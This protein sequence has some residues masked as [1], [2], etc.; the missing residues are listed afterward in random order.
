MTLQSEYIIEYRLF[1]KEKYVTMSEREISKIRTGIYWETS[2]IRGW[3]NSRFT[4]MAF[5]E[6][7]RALLSTTK[8]STPVS[9]FSD[10]VTYDKVYLPSIEEIRFGFDIDL[11]L[12]RGAGRNRREVENAPCSQYVAAQAHSVLSH[13]SYGLRSRGHIDGSDSY[14][15]AENFEGHALVDGRLT[16][17]KLNEPMGI[18]PVIC[19]NESDIVEMQ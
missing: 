15:C 12:A 4:R 5:K 16:L 14:K 11:A 8:I 10:R 9:A 3:L 19:V 17:W 13:S 7:E 6:E 18:R 1:D 2:E